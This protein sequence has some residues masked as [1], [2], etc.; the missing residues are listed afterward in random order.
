MFAIAKALCLRVLLIAG[1]IAVTSSSFV[2]FRATAQPSPSSRPI[3]FVHGW[4]GNANDW[5]PLI[6]SLNA[7]LPSA[8][9]TSNNQINKTV[10]VVEYNSTKAD[11]IAYTFYQASDQLGNP[12]VPFVVPAQN[13]KPTARFFA[14]QFY[15]PW[16]NG[17]EADNVTRISVLNKAYELKKVIEEIKTITN[18]TSVNVVAHS[19]GGLD[20]RAY[21]ENLAS[22][23]SCYNYQ[24]NT[25]DSAYGSHPEYSLDTCLPGTLEAS[26]ANDVANI[27]TVDTPHWG[28]PLAKV[29]LSNQGIEQLG[30]LGGPVFTCQAFDSTNKTELLL[31]SEG[32][33]GLIEELNYDGS[34][35]FGVTPSTNSV[36]IQAIQDYFID[37]P[38][39]CCPV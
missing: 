30:N 37:I 7:T 22:A 24:D 32:G 10:Y 28:S 21:V 23:G 36:P 4:C 2:S 19:M 39:H 26:Y 5:A 12:V 8:M 18:V 6:E 20:V 11:D 33:P 1:L 25:Q 34:V 9:F 15:D 27:I 14:I 3:L 38:N 35:N 16:S 13:I 17:S 29:D 31:S